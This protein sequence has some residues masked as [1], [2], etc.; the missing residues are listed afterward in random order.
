MESSFVAIFVFDVYLGCN[1]VLVLFFTTTSHLSV[2]DESFSA[3]FDL[4]FVLCDHVTGVVGAPALSVF[5]KLLFIRKLFEEFVLEQLLL[6]PSPRCILLQTLVN[7]VIEAGGPSCWKGLVRLAD[8][9]PHE[10]RLVNH[11]FSERRQVCGQLLREAAKVP[12]IDLLGVFDA[13]SD[14][15]GVKRHRVTLPCP[16]LIELI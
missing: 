6:G 3:D 10:L 13:L 8:D 1:C 11:P 7:E 15:R 4:E 12:D 14:F 9:V 5:I 2:R 16:L